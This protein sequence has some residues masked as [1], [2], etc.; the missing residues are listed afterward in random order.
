MFNVIKYQLLK[1]SAH[2]EIS[3]FDNVNERR[4]AQRVFSSYLLYVQIK[5]ETIYFIV[6]LT[7]SI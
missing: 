5:S 6:S 7:R 3:D 2:E 4:L 1:I